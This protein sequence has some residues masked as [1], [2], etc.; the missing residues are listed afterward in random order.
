MSD[1]QYPTLIADPPWAYNIEG[2]KSTLEH[3]P[4]RDAHESKGSGSSAQRYGKMGMRELLALRPPVADNA[5]LY[6]WF[7]NAFAVEAHEL[8]RAWGFEPKTIVTWGKV[9][10]DGTPSMK[11]GYY[12]RGATEHFLFAVRGRMRLTEGLALPTLMLS[13]RLPHSVKPEEFYDV[14]EKASPG[15]YLE[16]FARRERPG[17]DHW[18]NELDTDVV[19]PSIEVPT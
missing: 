15:P 17:W 8:A 19:I 16:M 11:M 6:L 14:V 5:H 12:F 13:K 4:N 18:G 1:V 7:T 3:R 9:K 10:P 2:P